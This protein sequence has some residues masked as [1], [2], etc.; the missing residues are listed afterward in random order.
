M[1]LTSYCCIRQP[2]KSFWKLLLKSGWQLVKKEKMGASVGFM[3]I[4]IECHL[5][6][7]SIQNKY[8]KENTTHVQLSCH[9]HPQHFYFL[10]FFHIKN[11]KPIPISF[12]RK[13]IPHFYGKRRD[14]RNLIFSL[15]FLQAQKWKKI[16]G[17]EKPQKCVF[18]QRIRKE[19]R[20]RLH[21]WRNKKKGIW[22]FF[23]N[24]S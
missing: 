21:A 24:F 7:F 11:R 6:H 18:F 1:T 13:K 2:T 20:E 9:F 17:K 12:S 22:L 3:D 8:S 5:V 19:K 10:D 16:T 14:V 23:F 4:F 15:Y